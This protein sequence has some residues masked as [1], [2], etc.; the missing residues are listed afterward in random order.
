MLHASLN[1]AALVEPARKPTTLVHFL[2]NPGKG[3]GQL[4]FI[5]ENFKPGDLWVCPWL[6]Y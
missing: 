2:A 1:G 6:L 4:N 5:P 3:S